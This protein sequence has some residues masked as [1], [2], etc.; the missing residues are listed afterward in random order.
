M[1]ASPFRGVGFQAAWIQPFRDGIRQSLR[2]TDRQY[3]EAVV[4]QF[5]GST[6]YQL[7]WW[8]EKSPPRLPVRM[9][10]DQGVGA[11][12]NTE[13]EPIMELT[14]STEALSA[15]FRHFPSDVHIG[16]PVSRGLAYYL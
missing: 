10:R 15:E 14:D 16:G 13:A 11:D 6:H 9:H 7:L 8:Q 12:R 4:C 5:S 2:G 3:H 1:L